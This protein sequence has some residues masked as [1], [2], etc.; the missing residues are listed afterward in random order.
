MQL[1]LNVEHDTILKLEET[2]FHHKGIVDVLGMFMA[3]TSAVS[4][5]IYLTRRRGELLESRIGDRLKP[6]AGSNH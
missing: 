6:G 1:E 5:R 2:P 3:Q 4:S